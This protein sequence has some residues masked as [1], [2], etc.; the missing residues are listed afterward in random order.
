MANLL[1]LL[2]NGLLLDTQVGPCPLEAEVRC[3]DRLSSKDH[4]MQEALDA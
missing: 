4:T 1:T 2:V 3:G